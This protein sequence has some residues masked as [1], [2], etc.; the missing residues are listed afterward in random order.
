MKGENFHERID[1]KGR[2]RF[3]IRIYPEAKVSVVLKEGKTV[4]ELEKQA[5]C[6]KLRK[7]SGRVIRRYHGL[8][9][10]RIT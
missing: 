1:I 10:L 8:V 2:G 7:T 5:E 9:I 6:R 3:G 4:A